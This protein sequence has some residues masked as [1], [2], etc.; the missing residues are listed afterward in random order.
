MHIC[1]ND[2]DVGFPILRHLTPGTRQ[3]APRD[4]HFL[5]GTRYQDYDWGYSGTHSN[6]PNYHF[7]MGARDLEFDV[8]NF[9]TSTPIPNS[10]IITLQWVADFGILMGV[11]PEVRHP[12]K[13]P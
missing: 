1:S 11:I 4:F 3:P 7:T 6:P 2:I 10:L 9:W 13:T 12:P 8:G 5:L